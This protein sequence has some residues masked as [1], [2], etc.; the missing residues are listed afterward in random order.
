MPD[1]RAI[2]VGV[3]LIGAGELLACEPD[4]GNCAT[5]GV[6]VAAA[7]PFSPAPT[8]GS[9]SVSIQNFQFNP[10]SITVKSGT[11]VTWTNMDDAQHTVTRPL[12]GGG[13]Q[14]AGPDSPVLNRGDTYSYTYNGVGFFP[15][16]CRIHPSM[17]GTVEITR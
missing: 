7:E 2:A 9:V 4:A 8:S 17:S 15:Y 10:S 6:I 11:T 3:L 14:M 5:T 13:V 16:H 1:A 12:E